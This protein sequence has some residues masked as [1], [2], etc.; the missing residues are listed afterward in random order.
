MYAGTLCSD[1]A[2]DCNAWADIHCN[3][4]AREIQQ[5]LPVLG[6]FS[7]SSAKARRHSAGKTPARG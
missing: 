4:I 3:S 6:F 1:P 5:V 2:A 7:K